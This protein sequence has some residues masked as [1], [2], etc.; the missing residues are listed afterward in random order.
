M[1][2]RKALLLVA[3]SLWIALAG[4]GQRGP[5]ALRDDELRIVSLSPAITQVIIALG[6]G[7][8]IVGVGD[9]DEIAASGTASVGRY[10]DLDLE[11]LVSLEP[12]HVLA[13]T[14][15]MGLPRRVTGLADDGRFDLADLS[16]PYDIDAAIELI[17]AVGEAIGRGDA[18]RA[19][20]AQ[21][22]TRLSAIAQATSN[23]AKP[24]VLMAFATDP[25]M[26]SGVGTV[27]DELLTIAGGVNV[28]SEA[29]VT[30]P[31]FDREALVGLQPE[32]VFLLKPGATPLEGADDARLGAMQ[33]LE[34]EAIRSGRV[35]L[36]G[37]PAIL[38]PGPSMVQTAA[39]MAEAL[40]P[41]LAD[42]IR[43]AALTAEEAE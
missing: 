34:I 35:Y 14:G 11:R 26:A 42:S 20:A 23:A 4:C 5:A 1:Q 37:D 36:L 32:V 28:A 41:D 3:A 43:A 31:V 6:L 29:E 21:T 19:L 9:G 39:V 40:H 27:N 12:T 15:E 33:N 30:A 16:Y 10:V 17:A 25:V 8:R 38:L 2:R 13:M 22:Q 7:D 18:G 24:M